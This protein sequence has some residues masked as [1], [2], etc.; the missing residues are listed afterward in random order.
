MIYLYDYVMKNTF[1]CISVVLYFLIL[2]LVSCKKSY[3]ITYFYDDF[4]SGTLN[5]WTQNTGNIGNINS[6]YILDGVLHG[7]VGKSGFSY[8]YANIINL[9]NDY[10]FTA[11]VKNISSVDQQFVFRVSEDKKEYYLVD[12]RYNDI[13][14]YWDNNNIKVFRVYKDHYVT[15]GTYPS[16]LIS[17]D[18]DITQNLF[19]K[20]KVVIKNNNIKVYFDDKLAIN[21][22]DED[23]VPL[24]GVGVGLMTW[25][26]DIPVISENI[27]YNVKIYDDEVLPRNKIIVLPGL[28]ASWNAEA[29]MLGSTAPNFIWKMTPFV[30]NYDQLISSFESNGLIKNQDFFV[31]NY[32]WRKPLSKIVNDFNNYI[33]SLDLQTGE[34][35]NLVGHSLGGLVARIWTQDHATLVDKTITL[36][37]PH[38][39]AVKAYEAWNGAKISDSVDVASVGL[40]ILLKLQQKNGDTSVQTLKKYAPIVM[41]LI[42]TFNFLKKNENVIFQ[43]FN[44]FLADK[45]VGLSTI[46]TQLY[47]VDGI[48]EDTKEWINL[49]ERS[50]FDRMLGIWDDGRPLLSQFGVGDGTVLKKSAVVTDT[51]TTELISNHGELVDKSINWVL[52]KLGLGVVTNTINSYPQTQ[53]VFY[54]SSSA[55]IVVNC[56]G[57]NKVDI[58]GWVIFENQETKNCQVKLTGRDYEGTYKLVAG[59]RNEWNYFEGNIK[60]DEI[61]K[62]LEN[63]TTD[64]WQELRYFFEKIDANQALKAA[65]KKNIK[66]CVE[67]YMLFRVT[68]ENFKYSE[69][70]LNSLKNIL[71]EKKNNLNEASELYRMAEN[72]KKI[73]D[74]KIEM[75]NKKNIIVTYADSLN[76]YQAE[77]LLKPNLNFGSN[78]LSEKLFK[79]I[80][81]N[82]G[83]R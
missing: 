55:N 38:F 82:N 23:I 51:E 47:T 21:A 2:T 59:D 46:S 25:G 32:D 72:Q 28:G 36:G 15:L 45:N 41:N 61:I 65:N 29:I 54:L 78:Y 49:G 30:K 69:E 17:R 34:K 6:W 35:V 77:N 13:N 9:P 58:E 52:S 22:E 26:G 74:R 27:F 60:K 37:T 39:G 44:Q 66:E 48:G 10:T 16:D 56:G 57:V 43:N 4:S 81:R 20:V 73:I 80:L 8:L 75:S 62:L 24:D 1:I 40:N 71:N 83:G 33:D 79:L 19:H 76:Y 68:R 11:D 64:N 63:Q 31:W 5:K 14:W 3:A 67:A 7:R 18:Y 42:P 53:A 50:I 12:Y 70:I